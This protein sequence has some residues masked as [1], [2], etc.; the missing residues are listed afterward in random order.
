MDAAIICIGR[1]CADTPEDLDCIVG[2]CPDLLGGGDQAMAVGGCLA[3][4]AS[5]R[6]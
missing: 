1:S 4:S 3:P 6:G 2:A 5:R